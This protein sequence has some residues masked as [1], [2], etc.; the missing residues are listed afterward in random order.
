MTAKYLSTLYAK[1]PKCP[2]DDKKKFAN[3]TSL[4][5]HKLRKHTPPILRFFGSCLLCGELVSRNRFNEH[6]KKACKESENRSI[7]DDS[8]LVPFYHEHLSLLFDNLYQYF[9]LTDSPTKLI[10][11]IKKFE[12]AHD[13]ETPPFT[14]HKKLQPP[15][16]YIQN[17]AR[18]NRLSL[19]TLPTILCPQNFFKF[20]QHY[21]DLS[22]NP[23]V[24]PSE[25]MTTQLHLHITLNNVSQC[26][27]KVRSSL[28]TL[29]P[30][31]QIHNLQDIPFPDDYIPFNEDPFPNA[32]SPGTPT[33]DE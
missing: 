9:D 28:A 27:E 16:H 11:L 24:T 8:Q 26:I 21:T 29:Q 5:E 7:P 14:A 25:N 20:V 15:D 10:Q 2:C 4:A 13:K 1:Q 17:F 31:N 3:T 6:I 30:K 18:Q 33:L 12:V 22:S 19:E 23:L 32:A